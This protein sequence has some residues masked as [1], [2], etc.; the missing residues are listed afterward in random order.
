[1]GLY[2]HDSFKGDGGRLWKLVMLDWHRPFTRGSTGVLR[3]K[4]ALKTYRATENKRLRGLSLLPLNVIVHVFDCSSMLYFFFFSLFYLF[5]FANL[6]SVPA[7]LLLYEFIFFPSSTHH[8]LRL[9]FKLHYFILCIHSSPRSLTVKV[10][11]ECDAPLRKTKLL[12]ALSYSNFYGVRQC[13]NKI[14]Y[15]TIYRVG[16]MESVQNILLW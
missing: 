2:W 4:P 5:W 11:L 1:M 6:S 14:S 10:H 16:I 8:P 7:A 3:L 13:E 15:F 9:M 12:E